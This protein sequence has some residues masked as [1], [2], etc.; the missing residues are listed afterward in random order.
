METYVKWGS[1][2]QAG[3]RGAMLGYFARYNEAQAAPLV[4]QALAE[5]PPGQDQSFLTDLTRANYNDSIDAILRA[6]LKGPEPYAA[7]T[8]AYV[9]S[10]GGPESDRAPIEARLARWRKEWGGRAPELD[11]E[12]AGAALAAQRM[13]EVNLMGALLNA[14]SW[15]PSDEEANRLKRGCVTKACRQYYPLK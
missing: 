3:T 13:V 2:W 11:A 12:R 5:I 6:R 4:E 15:K 10:L 1:K 9:M 8:A 14:K 7:G